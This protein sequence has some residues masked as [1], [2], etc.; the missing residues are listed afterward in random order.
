[1]TALLGS[2]PGLAAIFGVSAIAV[3]FAGTRLSSSTDVLA[4]RYHLGEALGGVILL[5]VATNLPEI[6]ITSTAATIPTLNRRATAAADQGRLKG[7]VP[8][9]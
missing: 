9:N 7:L 8:L 4:D 6:A 5:A 3:W 1:M 2:L